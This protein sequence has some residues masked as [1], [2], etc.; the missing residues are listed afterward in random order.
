LFSSV[1]SLLA[2]LSVIKVE[3]QLCFIT[4]DVSCIANSLLD[5][6]ICLDYGNHA[7]VCVD[8]IKAQ[9]SNTDNGSMETVS[10]IT[11]NENGIFSFL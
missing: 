3:K 5:F 2:F 4:K 11:A 10:D 6:V 7:N 1:N 9:S 8:S